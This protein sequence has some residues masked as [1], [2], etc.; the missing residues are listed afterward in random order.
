[1]DTGKNQ[2]FF[3]ESASNNI[4]SKD[5]HEV[6]KFLKSLQR[7]SYLDHRRDT[8]PSLQNEKELPPLKK[9]KTQL[10]FADRKKKTPFMHRTGGDFRSQKVPLNRCSG[11]LPES[12]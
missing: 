6:D 10:E 12:L 9:Q 5:Q 7:H 3:N 2:I 11:T 1:M 8:N 4:S